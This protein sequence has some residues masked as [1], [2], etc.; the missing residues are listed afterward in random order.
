MRPHPRSKRADLPPGEVVDAVLDGH[1][2]GDQVRVDVRHAVTASLASE[3][4]TMDDAAAAVPEHT[5]YAACSPPDAH[6]VDADDGPGELE[7][8][9]GAERRVQP[10]PDRALLR[11]A[12]DQRQLLE[13]DQCRVG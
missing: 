2:P 7:G 12:P 10:E 9:L 1:D 4:Q 3:E 13:D 5:Q 11:P 6:A 8:R